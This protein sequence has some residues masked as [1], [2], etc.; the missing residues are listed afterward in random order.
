MRHM[1]NRNL[2]DQQWERLKP[3]LP[4][5]KP[6]TGRT[7]LN[8]RRIINGILWILRTGAPWDDLPRRYGKR[9]TVSSR[10]YRWRKQGIWDRIFADLQAQAATDGNL[11]WTIHFVDSTIIRAH[12][13]AAG[14]KDS[15]P[16]TEALGRSQGGVSTKLN[17][18]SDGQ[19]QP[20]TFVLQPG[21]Q[22]ESRAF[23]P[24]M[25]GGPLKR[26]RRGR[27]RRRPRRVCGD[28]ANSNRRIRRWLRKHGIRVTIPHKQ[29]ERRRGRF[30]KSLYKLRARVEQ[31]INRLKQFRRIATRYEK[32]A[33]NYLGMV[34]IGAI[35]LYL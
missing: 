28:K 8:H 9:G 20:L 14:A 1:S 5:Q 16:E 23:E 19:G 27:P 30:D 15:D 34:T 7:N 6:K 3:L 13:H 33:A 22:H 11:D 31:L 21:Q 24:L 18:R 29:N 17:V 2:T 26:W 4:P 32:R 35:L 10:Y 25:E 12:Q